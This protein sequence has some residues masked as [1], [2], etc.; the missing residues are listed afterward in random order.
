MTETARSRRGLDIEAGR[1]LFARECRFMRGVAALDQLPPAGVPEIAFAGRSNVGKS[2]LLNALDRAQGAGANVAHAGAHP[3][4]QLLRPRGPAG[5]G[6]PARLRLGPR[7]PQPG[8]RLDPICCATTCA[9]ARPCTGSACSWTLATVSSR[10]TAS[11]MDMLDAAAVTYQVVLTKIDN[12]KPHAARVPCGGH[13]PRGCAPGRG[14]PAGRPNQRPGVRS[15]SPSCGPN[16]P[17]SPG[18]EVTLARV[19]PA[20]I[21]P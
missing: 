2:S 9:G 11:F 15:A 7:L 3:A 19:V 18:D 16:S 10:R 8:R 5:P 4:T 13:V 12:L 17:A 14:P 21:S 1:L 6:R 20:G